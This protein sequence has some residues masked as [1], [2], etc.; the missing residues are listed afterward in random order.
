MCDL[1][2]NSE[3]ENLLKESKKLQGTLSALIM[4]RDELKLHICKNLQ[5]EYM[6]KIGTLEYKVYEFE[7]K[8]LRIKRKIEL[9]QMYFNRQKIVNIIEIEL[10]LNAEFEEYQENLNEKMNE[11][12]K[13]LERN[14]LD[15]LSDEESVEIRKLYRQ[16]VK[17][18]HPD[19]NPNVT[20]GEIE[21]FTKAVDAYKNGDLDTLR[22]ISMLITE[23]SDSD[24]ISDSMNNLKIK[25]EKLKNMIDL[26]SKEIEQIKDS[27]PYNQKELLTNPVKLNERRQELLRILDEYKHIYKLYETKLNDMLGGNTNV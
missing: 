21:L 4:E 19:L 11:I 26:I 2:I 14:N 17:K 18:L 9:I 25:I 3:Y 10:T 22:S 20:A 7:C 8:I 12:N 6:V 23:I 15:T 27:F 24:S 5:A 1:A 16:I 13:A